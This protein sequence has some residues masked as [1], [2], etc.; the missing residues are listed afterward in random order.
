M[1]STKA[2]TRQPVAPLPVSQI[3]L[4]LPCV[5]EPCNPP[6]AAFEGVH[7]RN[8]AKLGKRYHWL[9]PLP[10]RSPA[11][12]PKFGA[13]STAGFVLSG[14]APWPGLQVRSN[15]GIRTTCPSRARSAPSISP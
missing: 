12:H 11:G 15:I 10:P 1:K 14:V 9:L 13:V 8:D 3:G 4:L 6:H 7:S 5:Y 2:P